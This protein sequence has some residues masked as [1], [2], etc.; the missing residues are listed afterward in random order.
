MRD[1]PGVISPRA[2]GIGLTL[3]LLAG[4]QA[5]AGAGAACATASDCASPLTCRFGACRVACTANRD[6]PTGASCLSAPGGSACS[7]ATDLGCETGVGRACP[8]PLVCVADR[9]VST[10]TMDAEC[11]T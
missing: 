1:T 8:M 3:V 5:P 6:C 11:P 4:C 9:C 7:I 2:I 10:C